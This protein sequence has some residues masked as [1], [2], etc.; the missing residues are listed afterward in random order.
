M[1]VKP[2]TGG[3]DAISKTAE[4]FKNSA[5]DMENLPRENRIRKIRA[6]YDLDRYFKKFKNIDADIVYFL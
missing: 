5:I 2:L 6:F 1:L 3:L 4:G